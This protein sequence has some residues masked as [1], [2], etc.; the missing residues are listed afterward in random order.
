MSKVKIEG[1]ASGTGTFTIAAPN[2]NTDRTL[3]LP[4]EA[5]TV[6][7]SASDIQSQALGGTPVFTVRLSSDYAISANTQTVVPFDT[8]VYDT[9]SCY[10]TSTYKYTPTTAGY[11][12]LNAAVRMNGDTDYDIFDIYFFK[13]GSNVSNFSANHRRYTSAITSTL[14]YMN[15]TSDYIELKAYV[16]ASSQTIRGASGFDTSM[17]G[18]LVRAD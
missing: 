17:F 11:Y 18:F 10:S 15:G 9:D 2:S 12:W 7:T 8:I 3:T 6:L 5:G 16:N 4:D 14:V 13:N 1:N